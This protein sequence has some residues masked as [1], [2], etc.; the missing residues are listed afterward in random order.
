MPGP[1]PDPD[2]VLRGH[3]CELSALH[4]APGGAFLVSGDGDGNVALWDLLRRKRAWTA[5]LHAGSVLALWTGIA[6]GQ[7][8]LITHGRDHL[9]HV[10]PFRPPAEPGK[11][12][13]SIIVNTL[14]YCRMAVLQEGGRTVLAVPSKEDA[15]KIDLLDVAA[16]AVICPPLAVPDKTEAKACGI[17]MALAFLTSPQSRRFLAAA[18]ESGD[19]A[20]FDAEPALAGTSSEAPQM[21]A[22]FRVHEE[23]VLCMSPSP[24]SSLLCT[25][26]ADD[27]LGFVHLAYQDEKAAVVTLNHV[28]IRTPGTA[29]ALVRPDGKLLISGG[30][31]GKIRLVSTRRK[32]LAVLRYHREGVAALACGEGGRFAS[33]GKDGRVAVWTVYP[34]K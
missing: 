11:P 2:F 16:E 20:L 18:Y 8:V 24:D 34:D 9:V 23:P 14:N 21:V 3:D 25:G 17:V 5:R 28:G 26:S 1:P 13:K 15:N 30:W 12:L 7:S 29:C 19:V 33:G 4:F 22:K 31:D 27:S 32:P 10:I 6:D